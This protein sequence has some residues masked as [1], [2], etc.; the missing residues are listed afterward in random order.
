MFVTRV[1]S[2]IDLKSN[3]VVDATRNFLA[4]YHFSDVLYI[5]TFLRHRRF[6]VKKV[7]LGKIA[8]FNPGSAV[9]LDFSRHAGRGG[10]TPP[11]DFAP[12]C[13]SDK[14]KM[15]SKARQKSL[16]KYFGKFSLR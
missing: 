8:L 13:R 6:S 2:S 9:W 7:S 12:R 5:E 11:S 1:N 3:L 14:P 16:R 10:G 15:R 4:T